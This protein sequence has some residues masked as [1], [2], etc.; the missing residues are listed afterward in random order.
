MSPGNP[1]EKG[2]KNK[3]KVDRV[4]IINAVKNPL[5]FFVLVVL[6][7]EAL[8]G[9]L[10]AQGPNQLTALY[11]MFFFLAVLIAV[12]VFFAYFR[13]EVVRSQRETERG[14]Q[15]LRKFSSG[16]SDYWG[17]SI[18]PSVPSALSV[19]EISPDPVTEAIKMRRQIDLRLGQNKIERG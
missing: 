17:E 7:I 3:E 11:G 15:Q 13:P 1:K 16:L 4:S 19:V 8:L 12:V 14:L 6:V 2:K 18:H 5:N 9:G 10:A